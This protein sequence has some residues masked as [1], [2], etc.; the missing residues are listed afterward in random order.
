MTWKEALGKTVRR[1]RDEAGLTQSELAAEVGLDR[2]QIHRIEIGASYP[3]F[4]TLLKIAMA[5][6]QH[7][8]YI[9]QCAR[10]DLNPQPAGYQSWAFA[11]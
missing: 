5:L 6:K 2:N 7:P 11:A 1:F 3:K 8:D 10:E 4:P 9:L